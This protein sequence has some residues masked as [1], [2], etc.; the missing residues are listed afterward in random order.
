MTMMKPH[1]RLMATVALIGAAFTIVAGAQP[2][3]PD[4][5]MGDELF[6]AYQAKDESVFTDA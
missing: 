6:A 5:M 2:R 3:R 4:Q 1:L